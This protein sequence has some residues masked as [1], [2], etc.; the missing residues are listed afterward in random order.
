MQKGKFNVVT[1]G[2][3]GSTGK[4]LINTYLA[5]KHRPEILSCTNMPNAGHTSIIP[6]RG[7]FKKFVAKAIPS[8]AILNNYTED[9]K[10]FYRPEVILG[11][12]SAFT[13]EQLTKECVE[14]GLPDLIIH[15]RAGVVTEKHAE[16]ERTATKHIAS[17]MQGSGACLSEKIMRSQDAKLAGS[18]PEL[19]QYI[20][21]VYLPTYVM[22]KM[23][24]GNTVL[25]EGSQGFSL[26]IH[27]GSH[28]PQCTSRSCTTPQYL[29]DMG[30][31]PRMLGD[32]YLV[33]RPYP[34]RVGN[35]IEEGVTVGHSGGHYKDNYEITWAD[36]AKAAGAPEE[37]MAGE[38]TTVTKRLR[39]VFT[40]S[41][42]QFS[43]AV[44][45]NGA[46]KVCLNFA[47]YVDWSC[48]GKNQWDDLGDKVHTWIKKLEDK[49]QVEVSLVGTGPRVDQVCVRP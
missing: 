18:Y 43:Q 16:T 8:S 32:V 36:V 28:Y 6:D 14:C 49:H 19:Q 10:N 15:P 20:K 42:V 35:V 12:S 44:Q 11:A 23:L 5:W 38:L 9:D 22:D 13:I 7:G 26:D 21:D 48:Y 29:T 27:H 1:D 47:N 24:S 30:V 33:I 34:I 3:W 31:S 25:H 4:G 2:Q 17:T 40:W 37:V 46:N 45:V 39:R 41:D